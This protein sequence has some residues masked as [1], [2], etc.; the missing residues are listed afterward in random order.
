MSLVRKWQ[1]YD[2]DF[3]EE[4]QYRHRMWQGD[5]EHQRAAALSWHQYEE[6]TYVGV[7]KK[8]QKW[9][10]K[11]WIEHRDSWIDWRKEAEAKMR[12]RK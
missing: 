9:K 4:L 10:W 7:E 2:W 3:F 6:S 11:K 5:Y 1:M 8:S 12:R